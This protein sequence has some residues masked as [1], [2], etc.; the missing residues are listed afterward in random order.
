MSEV[1]LEAGSSRDASSTFNSPEAR[2]SVGKLL[3]MA[4]GSRHIFLIYLLGLVLEEI[5]NIENGR[6]SEL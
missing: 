6:A 4:R 5:R 3:F 2:H 1:G